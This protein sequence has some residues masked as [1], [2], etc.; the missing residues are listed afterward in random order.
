MYMY[1]RACIS[2]ICTTIYELKL[3]C[4][5]LKPTMTYI[6]SLTC[7]QLIKKCLYSNN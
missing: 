2:Y 5:H 4:P 7:N 3:Q 1:P 6:L